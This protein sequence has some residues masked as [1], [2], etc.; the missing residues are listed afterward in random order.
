MTGQEGQTET[1]YFD[2]LG[3]DVTVQKLPAMKAQLLWL[4]LA[5]VAGPAIG[6]LVETLDGEKV[7][8]F[9]AGSGGGVNGIGEA[10]NLLVSRLTVEEF[11]Q[12]R[13]ELLQGVFFGG[14]PITKTAD[15][16]FMG[17]TLALWKVLAFALEVN[18][19]DFFGG[20]RVAVAKFLARKP[21]NS[22]TSPNTSPQPG[23]AGG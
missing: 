22:A 5:R 18:F 17:K 9:A 11:D 20:V 3:G 16:V 7:R 12:L 21:Q 2:E 4:R 14:Q 19:A 15:V 1:R 6:K 10:L 13:R 23:P 8:D